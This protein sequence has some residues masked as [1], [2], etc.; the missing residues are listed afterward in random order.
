M[1]ELEDLP[2]YLEEDVGERWPSAERAVLV[3]AVVRDGP[4]GGDR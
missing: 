3:G 4:P 2:F 1:A